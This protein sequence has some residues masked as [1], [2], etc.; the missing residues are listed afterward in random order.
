MKVSWEGFVQGRH[1]WGIVAQNICR[2][3]SRRG[4][5]VH[6]QGTQGYEC[7]PED[8]RKNVVKQLVDKDYDLQLSYTAPHNWPRHMSHGVKNRFAIWCY[9]WPILPV[10]FAK[11]HAACDRV[12]APSNFA[13][14]I[15]IQ[16]KIP[17]DK[18]VMVPHGI[19]LEDYQDDTK[20]PL[21]TKKKVKILVNIG[22]QHLRKN[23]RGL[24]WAFGKAFTKKDDVCLVA[25]IS[26]TATQHSFD[27]DVRAVYE[28]FRRKH[29]NHA[30][31]ELITKYVPN[32]A[33]LYNACDAVYT[34]SYTEG[35]Y[36][37]GLEAMAAGKPNIAPRYGGQLDF[38]DD[39]NSLLIE[40]KLIQAP[41]KMQYWT[42][43]PQN[44]IF[45]SNLDDAADKLRY[46][47]ENL[48]EF[49]AKE[50]MLK[51]IAA[52]YTWTSVTDQILGLCK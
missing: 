31:I 30:E 44:T 38:L 24:L 35:F 8:L 46:L 52:G 34:M 47:V 6:M 11:Y 18:I 23:I 51:K 2:N 1:S 14:D 20:Y 3:L 16:N 13:R 45:D 32:M 29:P 39:S 41:I 10:G 9:E 36:M 48:D 25:K 43:S 22:Q 26:A 49:K 37:P 4:H 21:Q 50:S 17:E 40:G 42:G 15:F 33:H 5:T 19:N 7:F 27:V 28:E 12:L